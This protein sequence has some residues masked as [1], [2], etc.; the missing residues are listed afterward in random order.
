MLESDNIVAHST[1]FLLP[2]GHNICIFNINKESAGW[3]LKPK[4][5]SSWTQDWVLAIGSIGYW[6]PL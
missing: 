3:L 6:V 4:I 1:L 5:C 2:S